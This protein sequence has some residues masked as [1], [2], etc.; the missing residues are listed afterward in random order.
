MRLNKQYKYISLEYINELADD[1]DD[2]VEQMIHAYL[3]SIPVNL[4]KLAAAIESNDLEEI[5]FHAHKLK[6]SFNFIG[7]TQIGEV[8][9][10][11]ES[12][13]KNEADIPKIKDCM[14]EIIDAADRVT[15]EL[16]D[17][18]AELGASK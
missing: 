13:C 1:D 15:A 2:F 11:V 10:Q 7:C 12:Y 3:N 8:F 14:V 16:Q 5:I 6:G 18:L 9:L 4:G 17:V